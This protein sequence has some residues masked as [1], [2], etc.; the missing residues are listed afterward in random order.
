[1][2]T[3]ILSRAIDSFA[4]DAEYEIDECTCI[5]RKDTISNTKTAHLIIGLPKLKL[6]FKEKKSIRQI[7]RLQLENIHFQLFMQISEYGTFNLLYSKHYMVTI[8]LRVKDKKKISDIILL[9]EIEINYIHM[10]F[11]EMLDMVESEC[12]DNKYKLEYLHAIVYGQ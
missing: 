6:T 10:H 9:Q 8:L 11:R 7:V 2:F 3:D 1:M 12:E 5:T 4:N